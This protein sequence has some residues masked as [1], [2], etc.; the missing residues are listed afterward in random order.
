MALVSEVLLPLARAWRRPGRVRR[1]RQ[2]PGAVPVLI[3]MRPLW[4]RYASLLDEME[5]TA[6]ARS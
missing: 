6:P 1:V 3:G 5:D 2:G 4:D